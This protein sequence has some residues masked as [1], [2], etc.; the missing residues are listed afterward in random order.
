MEVSRAFGVITSSR[1][2]LL[3]HL[4]VP[5]HARRRGIATL[6]LYHLAH[7]LGGDGCCRIELD[8][9][10]DRYRL[11]NNVYTRAGFE[12]RSEWGPEMTASRRRVMSRTGE[13]MMEVRR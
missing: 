12:Y 4:Y 7:R 6:L 3:M 9:M 8:D 11:E 10:S 13:V 1:T 2:F 5:P